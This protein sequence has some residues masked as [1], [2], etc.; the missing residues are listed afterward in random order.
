MSGIVG[1]KLNIRGSGLIGSLGTD[2]QHLLSAGAG[3][4]NVFET[5]AAAAG[6]KIGQ[7]LQ[8]TETAAVTGNTV[9][10][11]DTFPN[12]GTVLTSPAITPAATSSKIL[13]MPCFNHGTMLGSHTWHLGRG[14][15]ELFLADDANNRTLGFM[16][17]NQ[18]TSQYHLENI[19]CI[20]LDSPATTSATTYVVKIS[21]YNT[22]EFFINRTSSDRD[23]SHGYDGRTTSSFTLMEVLA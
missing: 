5:I 14:T 1:S 8:S 15:T 20:F 10:H 22:G 4:S 21:G 3:V 9:L 23:S 13:V 11:T 12:W 2:G 16:T 18:V 19:A 6:G 7:V 17:G